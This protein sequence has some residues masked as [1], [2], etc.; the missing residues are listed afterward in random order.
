MRA[1]DELAISRVSLWTAT[2]N[3]YA[4]APSNCGL[5]IGA[6]LGPSERVGWWRDG[7]GNLGVPANLIQC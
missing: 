5:G 3:P 6:G 7:G 2:A 1:G 4:P